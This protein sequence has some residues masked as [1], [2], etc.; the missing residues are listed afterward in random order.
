[1]QLVI[2]N[3]KSIFVYFGSYLL[4]NNK[5]TVFAFHSH[6]NLSQLVTLEFFLLL[7]IISLYSP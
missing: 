1:M 2:E 5:N 7:I 6:G 3:N 4:R